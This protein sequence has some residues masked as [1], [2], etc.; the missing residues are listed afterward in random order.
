[1]MLKKSVRGVVLATILTGLVFGFEAFGQDTCE[2][3]VDLNI[4]YPIVEEGKQEILVDNSSSSQFYTYTADQVGTIMMWSG[5]ANSPGDGSFDTDLKVYQSTCD[6]LIADIDQSPGLFGNC[7]YTAEVELGDTYIFEWSNENWA[8]EFKAHFFFQMPMDGT[9]CDETIQLQEGKNAQNSIFYDQYFEYKAET[10]GTLEVSTCGHENAYS[11]YGMEILE[12][13]Q[14]SDLSTV[15]YDCDPDENYEWSTLTYVMEEGEVVLVKA[16]NRGPYDWKYDFNASFAPNDGSS[17]E[18]AQN[19]QTGIHAVDNSQGDHWFSFV[20]PKEGEVVITTGNGALAGTSYLYQGEDT[21]VELHGACEDGFIKSNDG[22]FGVSQI[23]H[24]VEQDVEY[25]IMMDDVSTSGQYEF[26]LFYT[27]DLIIGTEEVPIH[28]SMGLNEDYGNLHFTTAQWFEYE[29][30]ADGVFTMQF[31]T[32]YDSSPTVITSDDAVTYTYPDEDSGANGF[33]IAGT[34]GDKVLFSISGQLRNNTFSASLNTGAIV[35]EDCYTP[36]DLTS[37]LFS[38]GEE[39]F[40]VDIS[41]DSPDKYFSFTASEAGT[42]YMY[43]CDSDTRLSDLTIYDGFCADDNELDFFPLG[44]F[45]GGCGAYVHRMQLEVG[46]TISLAWKGNR[47]PDDG[48]IYVEAFMVSAF[49]QPTVAGETCGDAISMIEGENTVTRKL[50]DQYFS[51]T[52]PNEGVLE[53]STCQQQEDGGP[54]TRFRLLS[55]CQS[56]LEYTEACSLRYYMAAGESVILRNHDLQLWNEAYTFS[57]Q[58]KVADCEEYTEVNEGTHTVNNYDGYTFLRYQAKADGEAIVSTCRSGVDTQLKRYSAFCGELLQENDDADHCDSGG[59]KISF[60]VVKGQYYYLEV[61]GAD[62]ADDFDLDILIKEQTRGYTAEY[63]ILIN[64]DQL[65]LLNPHA[66]PLFASA[67]LAAGSDIEVGVFGGIAEILDQQGAP[68]PNE[69]DFFFMQTAVD[70]TFLL[71]F[72]PQNQFEVNVEFLINLGELMVQ[73]SAC[74][75]SLQ[76]PSIGVYDVAH[77]AQEDNDQWYKIT[78]PKSGTLVVTTGPSSRA[79]GDFL[80]FGEDTSIEVYDDCLFDNDPIAS[81]DDYPGFF[82]GSRLAINAIEGEEY[83]ILMI[84]EFINDSYQFEWFYEEDLRIGI[85][86]APLEVI[87]GVNEDFG[88]ISHVSEQWFAFE[89]EV[90]GTFDLRFD[91]YFDGIA[92]EVSTQNAIEPYYLDD[93]DPHPSGFTYTSTT[94]GDVLLFRLSNFNSTFN[95]TFEENHCKGEYTQIEDEDWSGWIT[96]EGDADKQ[97]FRFTAP[98]DGE[99]L[100]TNLSNELGINSSVELTELCSD[101]VLA[102]TDET[103]APNARMVTAVEQGMTYEL[104]WNLSTLDEEAIDLEA[105]DFDFYFGYLDEIPGQTQEDAIVIASENGFYNATTQLIEEQWFV[106]TLAEDGTVIVEKFMEG[107]ETDATLSLTISYAGYLDQV[108]AESATYTG[109]AG[110]EIYITWNNNSD[111]TSTDFQVQFVADLPC[112][113]TNVVEET[114]CDSYAFGED[115]YTVSGQYLGDFSNENGCDSLVVLNLTILKSEEHEV[116]EKSC[117][118]YIFDDVEYFESGDYQATFTNQEG[119]DSL[120]NL[121]LKIFEELSNEISVNG[122]IL[123]AEDQGDVSYQWIDCDL[124]E[125]LTGETKRQ[126]TPKRAGFYA[127]EVSNENCSVQSVCMSSDGEILSALELKTDMVAYP[128]PTTDTFH[129]ELGRNFENVEVKVLS[130]TGDIVRHISDFNTNKIAV[131]LSEKKGVYFVR[132]TA[133]GQELKTLRVIKE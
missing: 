14:G 126:L 91:T 83:Y 17:C 119:C 112:E 56:E 20:A 19:I 79:D 54:V 68:I 129:L 33:T 64:T 42:Y 5:F 100:V 82:G 89:I 105:Y 116:S 117:G 35:G 28:V 90:P 115:E 133:Q 41:E 40:E 44:L 118:S 85:E 57:M 69:D 66:E 122:V 61:K 25:F 30:L 45:G 107:I 50:G 125:E 74:D 124:G 27:E 95:A 108:D 109:L 8:G 16:A 123:F 93:D 103:F 131:D 77:I 67:R 21:R 9:A 39:V 49:F 92:T 48:S 106:Y 72:A 113:D 1:M 111:Y 24:I 18:Q 120:V 59:S 13:C 99:I 10:D 37:G 6:N 53:L 34:T 101:E 80:A 104:L 23:N 38:D 63:P 84:D 110:D 32:I 29:F 7:Q 114:A 52:A 11:V 130:I 96:V 2:L 22:A 70:S 81:N 88:H 98:R 47:H 127:V 132:V 86:V 46:Q 128:N 60:E 51:Y 4:N 15:D 102:D 31:T 75:N 97:L 76:I 65:T 36:I 62:L 3:A 78:A 94:I 12:N 71:R 73:G 55:D 121:S 26:E 87:L 58:L 43:S